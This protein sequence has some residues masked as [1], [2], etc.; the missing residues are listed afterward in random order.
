MATNGEFMRPLLMSVIALI[1]SGFLGIKC[2][3]TGHSGSGEHFGISQQKAGDLPLGEPH[4]RPKL[5]L[6][7]ALKIAQT[8]VQKQHS[9]SSSYWLFDARFILY[10]GNDISDEKKSQ[11]WA[12]QWMNDTK[13]PPT[14]YIVVSMDGEPMEVPSI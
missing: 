3:A 9:D 8:F 10:G 12:F 4:T 2:P 11:C 6:E 1:I 13:G 14:I 7:S 5:S